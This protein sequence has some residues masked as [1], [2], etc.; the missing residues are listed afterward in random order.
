MP[1]S[2]H[3]GRPKSTEAKPPCKFAGCEKTTEGG[4]KGFCLTHY[5]YTRRG[6]IDV[7]TGQQL[8]ELQR[9]ASYSPDARCSIEGCGRRPRANGM[10]AGH[11]S[12]QQL[13]IPMEGAFRPKASATPTPC[14][15]ADC[16]RRASSRG[17]CLRH[18]SR[19][20]SGIL[21]DQGNKLREP[22]S[23]GRGRPRAQEKW[24]SSDGYVLVKAPDGHPRARQDGS[25]L[26]HR[27][28]LEQDLGRVLEDWE[29]VHHKNGDR[30]DNSLENL[31]LMDGRA[32]HG[33][34]H[35]PGSDFDLPT[36]IRVL[37]QQ[38]D[39]PGELREHLLLYR[40]QK[41]Q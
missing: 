7:E 20:S 14:L 9:V 33:V 34:G 26:E 10:C 4:A 41:V 36:A 39:L 32:R 19:R 30:S 21:D 1:N 17:M 23:V 27:L 31:E 6:I 18:A 22:Y 3:P 24:F 11:L 8:R 37:A 16:G 40:S 38:G 13:G 28:V 29:I 35:P 12:R 15:V 5:V 2:R 25:I